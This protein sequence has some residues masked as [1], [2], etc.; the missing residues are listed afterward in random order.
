V[1]SPA[2]IIADQAAD[3]LREIRRLDDLAYIVLRATDSDQVE[4]EKA[5]EDCIDVL[6]ENGALL[7]WRYRI[8]LAKIREGL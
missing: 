3:H 2:E 1:N 6:F 4:A 7:M 8:V 5:L